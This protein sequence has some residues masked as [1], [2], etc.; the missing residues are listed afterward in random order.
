V[1]VVSLFSEVRDVVPDSCVDLEAGSEVKSERT[2]LASSV[3]EEGTVA[4]SIAVEASAAVEVSS[5]TVD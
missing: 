3:V 1:V 2:S 4:V 5:R